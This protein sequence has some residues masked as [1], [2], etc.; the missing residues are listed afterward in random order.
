MIIVLH[1]LREVTFALCFNGEMSRN[2]ASLK[3]FGNSFIIRR[4]NEVRD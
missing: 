3:G 4:E 1:D 2:K